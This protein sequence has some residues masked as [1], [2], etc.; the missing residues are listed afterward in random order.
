MLKLSRN[1]HRPLS[2]RTPRA[3][4]TFVPTS[5]SSLGGVRAELSGLDRH[6]Y[7]AVAR[8]RT[9]GLDGP[10]RQL[11]QAANRSVLWAVVAVL[12][13]AGGGRRGRRAAARGMVSIGVTSAFCNLALKPLSARRRPQREAAVPTPRH[14][15][16]PKS[17]S[18]PSGH[19]ASAF[20]FATSVGIEMPALWLPLHGL[21]AL[22]AY[23]RIHTGVHYPGDVIV[24][25]VV[26]SAT[27]RVVTRLA[28]HRL[29]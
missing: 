17:S 9:P 6:V 23:S 29:L 7:E 10:I 12:L 20:A 27:G 14:V 26:G 4:M 22:V 16:M 19:S 24:G 13:A 21:A 2:W 28:D 1:G 15:R 11:S 25:S 3:Q 5:D 8:T 18:F